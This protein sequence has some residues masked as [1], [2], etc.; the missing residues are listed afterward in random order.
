MRACVF[1]VLLVGLTALGG[2][3]TVTKSPA[4]VS[5][6]YQQM[7]DLDLRQI[8]DDW[9]LLWLADRQYR[10]TKWQTR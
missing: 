6:I 4:E 3:T 10:L 5:S 9:N 8:G 7:T 1:L 2:C